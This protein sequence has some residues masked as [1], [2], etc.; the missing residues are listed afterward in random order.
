VTRIHGNT[1]ERNQLYGIVAAAGEGAVSFPT[2]TST[3]NVLDISIAQNTVKEHTGG[4]IGLAGGVG[5]PNGRAGAVADNNQTTAIVVE[6][7][8]EGST[9]RGIELAAGGF[10]LASANALEVRVT[11]NTVCHNGTDIVGEGGESGNV[12][13]PVPNTG[14]GNVLEGE[15]VQNTATTVVVQDGAGAPGNQANVTQFNNDLCP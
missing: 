14:T 4:G 8:V 9:D 1:L 3:Q 2:G 13:F 15:V 7:T 5:S 6:N 11:G 10:G 12:L